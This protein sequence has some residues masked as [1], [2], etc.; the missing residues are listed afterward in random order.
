MRG[1]GIGAT[2]LALAMP[3]GSTEALFIPPTLAGPAA[4]PLIGT[5]PIPASPAIRAN[6]AAGAARMTRRAM[7]IVFV[8]LD[9]T[10]LLIDESMDARSGCSFADPPSLLN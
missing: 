7:A 2:L 4:I 5:F 8:L 9:I 3:L 10:R 1:G 6:E